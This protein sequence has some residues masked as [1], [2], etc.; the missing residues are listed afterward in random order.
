VLG[1]VVQVARRVKIIGIFV[2]A[3]WRN[4]VTKLS[5]HD[6][7]GSLYSH[8]DDVEHAAEVV[9]LREFDGEEQRV[10]IGSRH[11]HLNAK[12]FTRW[13]KFLRWLPIFSSWSRTRPGG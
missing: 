2:G 8:S 10:E 12:K 5:N 11:G 3:D 13:E 1:K 6:L 9:L 7:H 4:S